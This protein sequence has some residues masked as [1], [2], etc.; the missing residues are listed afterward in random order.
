MDCKNSNLLRLHQAELWT[1]CI[2]AAAAS[3]VALR[4]RSLELFPLSSFEFLWEPWTE[5]ERKYTQRDALYISSLRQNLIPTF[6]RDNW[7]FSASWPSM[8]QLHTWFFRLY[9]TFVLFDNTAPFAVENSIWTSPFH[10]FVKYKKENNVK[11]L[12]SP[13]GR[14]GRNVKKVP[15]L[16]DPEVQDVLWNSF[17]SCW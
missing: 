12:C 8:I 17:T 9:F 3:A 14:S 11:I 2:T 1:C 13:S 16:K 6:V 4:V 15:G 7:M 10:L 5:R